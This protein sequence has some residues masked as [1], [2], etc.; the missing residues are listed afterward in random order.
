MRLECALNVLNSS[1]Q[2]VRLTARTDCE[3]GPSHQFCFCTVRGMKRIYNPNMCVSSWETKLLQHLGFLS[4]DDGQLRIDY[5]S[6]LLH[7]FNESDNYAYCI[8]NKIQI[9]C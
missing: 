3:V 8:L 7:E 2:P 1:Q 5:L 4:F 6:S 9:E